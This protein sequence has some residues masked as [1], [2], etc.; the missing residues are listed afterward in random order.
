[1]SSPAFGVNSSYNP[2]TATG[3]GDSRAF[4]VNVNTPQRYTFFSGAVVER[5]MRGSEQREAIY[6]NR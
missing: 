6:V 4:G 3:G 1:M 2:Q 5:Q